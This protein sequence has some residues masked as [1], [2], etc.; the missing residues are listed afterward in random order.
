VNVTARQFKADW[1][2][3]TI[4]DRMNFSRVTAATFTDVL[5]HF[6]IYSSFFLAPALC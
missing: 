1:I 6:I 4:N 3:E 5:I 2:S